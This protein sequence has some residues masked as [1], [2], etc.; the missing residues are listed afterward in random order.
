MERLNFKT[1][2]SIVMWNYNRDPLTES[3]TKDYS[4]I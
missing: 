4:V 3:P 2:I 1:L